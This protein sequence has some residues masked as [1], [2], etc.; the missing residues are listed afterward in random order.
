MSPELTNKDFKILKFISE[1]NCCRLKHLRAFVGYN[2]KNLYR[3]EGNSKIDILDG[4]VS[5]KHS[6]YSDDE[7]SNML[8]VLDVLMHYKTKGYITGVLA[9]TKSMDLPFYALAKSARAETF[10]YFTLVSKGKEMLQCRLIDSENHGNVIVI[11][12]DETQELYLTTS[13]ARVEVHGD[14]I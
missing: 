4:V 9:D 2:G 10:L 8:K 12:E 7:K 3:L 5:V 6:R 11:L 13:V 14:L 1:F